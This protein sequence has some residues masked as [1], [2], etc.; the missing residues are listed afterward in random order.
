MTDTMPLTRAEALRRGHTPKELRGPQFQRLFRGVYLPAGAPVTL[1]QRA[2]AALLVA[3]PGAYVS[4]HTAA[5][6]WGAVAPDTDQTHVS[7]PGRGNRSVRDGICAHRAEASFPPTER[8]GVPVSAPVAVFLELAALHLDL[9]ALV[10]LGDSLVRRAKIT[11]EMLINA[12]TR[13]SGRGARLARRAAGLVRRGVDSAMETRL[14]L[15]IVL[16]GLPEPAVNFIIRDENGDW[17]LRFDLCYPELKLIIEYDGDQH[18]LDP[19]QWSRDLRRREWLERN[20]WRLI[21]INSDAYHRQP[22]ETL[23][24]IR[25]ALADRGCRDLPTRTPTTWDRHFAIRAA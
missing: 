23:L 18:R 22:R 3:P 6:L 13:W 12:A 11:P 17:A 2:R 9:V 4:H 15:L 7:I 16:A 24:R 19:Q 21:V 10:V 25:Q 5:R 1:L 8:R 20:G 14:R